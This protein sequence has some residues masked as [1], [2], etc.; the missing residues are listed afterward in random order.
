[1]TN[2]TA[3]NTPPSSSQ[4]V[5]NGDKDPAEALHALRKDNGPREKA[6]PHKSNS[7]PDDMREHLESIAVDLEAG[8]GNPAQEPENPWGNQLKLPKAQ[9]LF[10]IAEAHIPPED[11][12]LGDRLLCVGGA[13]LLVGPSGIGKSTTAVQQDIQWALGRPAFALKPSRPLKMLT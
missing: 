13:M 7:I 12:L 8:I 1:M 5:G 3:P 4:V 6:T 9:S 11:T 2:A 10:D